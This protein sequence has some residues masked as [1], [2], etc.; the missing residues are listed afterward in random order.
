MSEAIHKRIDDL[1]EVVKNMNQNQVQER[2]ESARLMEKLVE[3]QATLAAK[4]AEKSAYDKSIA[5]Q[6]GKLW[7]KTDKLADEVATLR[8]ETTANT[9]SRKNSIRLRN[10]FFGI[11]MSILITGAL[12]AWTSMKH[13]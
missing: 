9:E 11:V 13:G 6:I 4:F 2:R 8:I 1:T 7:K 12:F 5:E 10:G 3:G